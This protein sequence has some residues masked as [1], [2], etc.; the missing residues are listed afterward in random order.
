MSITTREAKALAA[1]AARLPVLVP[2]GHK[3]NVGATVNAIPSSREIVAVLGDDANPHLVRGWVGGRAATT[4]A[5][6]KPTNACV[7]C[8]CSHT[9]YERASARSTFRTTNGCWFR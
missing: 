3:S 7:V 4:S 8:A 6:S 5:T 1:L 9:P 2:T